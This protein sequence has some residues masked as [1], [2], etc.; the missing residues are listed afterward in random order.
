V[1]AAGGR[2]EKGARAGHARWGRGEGRRRG[3]GW[4]AGGVG[5]EEGGAQPEPAKGGAGA[6]EERERGTDSAGCPGGAA[7]AFCYSLVYAAAFS[8]ILN[9]IKP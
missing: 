9:S 3:V 7:A 4:G 1:A 2:A 5:N 8:A 6:G